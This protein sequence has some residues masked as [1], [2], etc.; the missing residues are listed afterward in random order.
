MDS[1]VMYQHGYSEVDEMPQMGYE[2]ISFFG[3]KLNVEAI[4]YKK[5]ANTG[6]MILT[7]DSYLLDDL[8]W[9]EKYKNGIIDWDAFKV[10]QTVLFATNE[11]VYGCTHADH[12]NRVIELNEIIDVGFYEKLSQ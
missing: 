6:Y 11:K 1:G 2:Q 7:K 4:P 5:V 9:N 12:L 10:G 8:K 3:K